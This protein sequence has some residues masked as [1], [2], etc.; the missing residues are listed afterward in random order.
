MKTLASSLTMLLV[1]VILT[2]C[3]GGGGS[4]GVTG[5]FIDDPVQNLNYVCSSG[6]SGV[7]DVNGYYTCDV[8]D[9]VTFSI[10]T[11]VIG[12]VAAQTAITT[13]YSLF[14]NNTEAAINL[15]RLLQT[16]D[17][18]ST[19]N[20]IVIDPDLG[21]K[22]PSDTNLEDV[23]FEEL[24][25]TAIGL[26]LVDG[27]TAQTSMNAAIEAANGTIPPLNGHIPVANA[28]TDQNVNTTS[29]VTLDGSASLDADSD[30]ITYTWSIT[31][32][33]TSS[34]AILSDATIVNPTFA[35][36]VDGAYVFSLVVN[37]GTVSSS[38]D[39]I[40]INATTANAAPVSNAGADQNIA[41]TAL[42]TLDGSA[43]S[44]ANGDS[45]TYAWSITSVPGGS[46]VSALSNAA[47]VNPTFTADV[48]GAYVFSLV[49]NDGTVNSSADA[50][51]V[52]ATTTLFASGDT[53]KGKTYNTVTSPYT[54]EVW[55]DRNL[56][57][58]QVCTS[59]DDTACYGD[60]YQW[61]R[62]ADGHEIIA[63]TTAT[64]A[65]SITPGNS[66]YI[67]P[68]VI[69]LDWTANGI[70]DNGSLRIPNWSKTDGSSVCPIGYRVPTISELDAE[71]L[72]ASS[73]VTNLAT[74]FSGFL[75]I[76]AAGRRIT[77]SDGA[78]VHAGSASGGAY[79]W[80]TTASGAGLVY[81]T[82]IR[83]TAA[84][85]ATSTSTPRAYALSIRC[86][87]D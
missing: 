52:N 62:N 45:L 17:S 11:F 43:S 5:T 25:Q 3:G 12:T 38:A 1:S 50:I 58:T 13:P 20:T 23:S 22:V 87:K 83:I 42:V 41:T 24:V 59:A 21:N 34:T 54:A 36:D 71:T 56:G 75:K 7:T 63:T 35:A 85:T 55:L 26:T 28:G 32:K 66:D 64:L 30:Q 67:D 33:P 70:D 46:S 49:V 60:R 86:I 81:S 68:T 74:G 10:G 76:A 80:T 19:A 84:A 48:D 79:L 78:L 44:D 82:N 14:P 15:A 6:V 77:S 9:D 31:S 4:G 73:P 18:G 16:L 29:T 65:T 40:T 57:A 51:T 47:I 37:D 39:T 72:S 2:A 61:G 69:P 8:G 27:T 53:W